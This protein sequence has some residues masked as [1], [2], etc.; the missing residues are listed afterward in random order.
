VFNTTGQ[1]AISLPLHQGPDGLPIG[2]HLVGGVGQE[3]LLLSL[4]ASLEEALPWSQ[5]RPAAYA[6]SPEP[7]P[8]I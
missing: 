2:M 8:T 6:G 1:P 4:A 7:I 3:A 5:R